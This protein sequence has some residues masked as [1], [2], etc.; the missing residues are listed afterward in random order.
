MFDSK[1]YLDSWKPLP[2]QYPM[3]KKPRQISENQF[4]MTD[5]MRERLAR[6]KAHV[7]EGAVDTNPKYTIE[8]HSE[9]QFMYCFD[10]KMQVGEFA[11]ETELRMFKQDYIKIGHH[12]F[13]QLFMEPIEPRYSGP[14]YEDIDDC[15]VGEF[16]PGIKEYIV[17]TIKLNMWLREITKSTE[18]FDKERHKDAI[19][20]AVQH[21]LE[22]V[23]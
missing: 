16:E 13:W 14:I 15:I 21:T 20:A 2:G 17:E 7:E 1:E 11:Y 23:L 12:L 3:P 5:E 4:V 22:K 18:D 9:S 8:M 19:L 6:W 10:I